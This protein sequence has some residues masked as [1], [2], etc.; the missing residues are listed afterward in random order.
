[1][2]GRHLFPLI[3]IILADLGLK[4]NYSQS[5][6]QVPSWTGLKHFESI[7]TMEFSDGQS[8]FDAL[9]LILP[10][11]VQLLP[12]NSPL[13]VENIHGK[14]FDF[15]KQHMLVHLSHD[16]IYMGATINYSTCVEEGFQQESGQAYEL[17][18]HKNVEAQMTKVD[19]FQEAI[20]SICIAVD[21]HDAEIQ[22]SNE[23]SQGDIEEDVKTSHHRKKA[24][25]SPQGHWSLG[26]PE[27]HITTTNLEEAKK[28]LPPF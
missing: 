10:C 11:I 5:M 20:G 12:T 3:L 2:F 8:Y 15:P 23:Q 25:A 22:K 27:K 16:I 21:A 6:Q 28:G 4:G 7:T 24:I 14:S 26:S 1:Q 19:E 18:N 13:K 9:K 17:T